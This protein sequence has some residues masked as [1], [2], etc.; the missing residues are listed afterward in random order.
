MGQYSRQK[1]AVSV[2]ANSIP[3]GGI[4]SVFRSGVNYKRVGESV[5]RSDYPDL[6]AAFPQNWD[7]SY[8][9]S[10]VVVTAGE[11]I[12]AMAYGNGKFIAFTNGGHFIISVDLGDSWAMRSAPFSS[13]GNGAIGAA[14]GNGVFV[15]ATNSNA[16]YFS[17]DG[18]G[19]SGSNAPAGAYGGVDFCGGKFIAPNAGSSNCMVSNDGI[20]WLS[21]NLPS[22]A[23]WG[24]VAFGNGTYVMIEIGVYGT[25]AAT[26]PDGA[27]WTARAMPESAAW[28]RIKFIN[29]LF[30]ASNSNGTNRYYTSPDG[31]NWTPRKNGLTTGGSVMVGNGLFVAFE[32]GAGAGVGGFVISSD[33]IAWRTLATTVVSS[34]SVGCYG[35]GV[36]IVPDAPANNFVNMRIHRLE[37]GGGPYKSDYLNING[38]AGSFVRVK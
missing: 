9:T 2:D 7:V 15:A 32:A 37:N 31:I 26:S 12:S 13:S 36:F 22:V 29:G 33:A 1:I 27:V 34:A 17:A 25:K 38:P 28:N 16:L 21:N 35:A 19:W 20:S 3:I 24:G 23:N 11:Y 10:Q 5:L 14:Y 4:A 8:K 6:D 18:E 30:I